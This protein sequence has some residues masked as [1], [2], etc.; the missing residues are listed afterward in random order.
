MA[1]YASTNAQI[2][3]LANG[4]ATAAAAALDAGSQE[5]DEAFASGGYATPIDLSAL[6]SGDAKTRLTARLADACRAIAAYLLSSP[7]AGGGKKG[8]SDK[9]EKDYK[10]IRAW[11]DKVAARQ[12]TVPPLSLAAG[13]VG[14][15]AT[16]VQMV[17]DSDYPDTDALFDAASVLCP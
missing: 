13:S 4:D 9:V 17:G 15:L 10:R 14:G 8:A 2:T 7:S 12:V 5:I 6:A 3:A 11:L 1:A 16:G